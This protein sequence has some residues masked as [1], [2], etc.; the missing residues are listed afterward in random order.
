VTAPIQGRNATVT[1][2]A[3]AVPVLPMTD[4]PRTRYFIKNMSGAG[5]VVTISFG[6]DK[7]PVLNEGVPLDPGDMISDSDSGLGYECFKGEILA[8]ATAAGTLSVFE[9]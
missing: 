2:G 7:A 5:V 8:I 4:P 9:A 3:A 6:R 1:V